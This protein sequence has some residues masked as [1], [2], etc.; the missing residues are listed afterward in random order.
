MVR[1]EKEVLIDFLFVLD[2]DL[3]TI[4][5]TGVLEY[6][7]KGLWDDI[8]N[9][10]T[11]DWNQVNKELKAQRYIKKYAGKYK[12]G[13]EGL[14]ILHQFLQENP[15]FSADVLNKRSEARLSLMK[16]LESI[17][18]DDYQ[19]RKGTSNAPKRNI[20]DAINYFI[21]E[22]GIW[23]TVDFYRTYEKDAESWLKYKI[24]PNIVRTGFK[25]EKIYTKQTG[26]YEDDW[27]EGTIFIKR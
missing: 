7:A 15:D 24:V 22:Q 23:I 5:P 11:P 20:P 19:K 14:K 8:K 27:V 16:Y 6:A 2:S 26:D 10:A 25:I 13:D 12:M 3:K 4:S 21:D 1:I 18:M 17:K 9:P